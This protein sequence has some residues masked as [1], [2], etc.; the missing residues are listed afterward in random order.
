MRDERGKVRRRGAPEPFCIAPVVDF[1]AFWN[2]VS[3]Q[4]AA[5]L[6]HLSS[7]K[8]SGLP[9][10]GVIEAIWVMRFSQTSSADRNGDCYGKACASIRSRRRDAGRLF[11]ANASELRRLRRRSSLRAM[12]AGHR[13]TSN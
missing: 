9:S 2:C 6:Q 3:P 7:T 5:F 4:S 10:R 12:P 1:S 11:A 8:S 13:A